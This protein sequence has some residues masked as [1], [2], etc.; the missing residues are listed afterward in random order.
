MF[1]LQNIYQKN[2]EAIDAEILSKYDELEME[3]MPLDILRKLLRKVFLKQMY[4]VKLSNHRIVN[5]T[6]E[7][8]LS[9]YD[10]D[11]MFSVEDLIA[12]MCKLSNNFTKISPDDFDDDSKTNKNDSVLIEVEGDEKKKASWDYENQGKNIEM[13][14]T[15]DDFQIDELNTKRDK[16]GEK[17]KE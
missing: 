15:K 5:N 7:E 3:L 10:N 6:L 12:I 8:L 13:N 2:L 17:I 1:K 14:D 11:G 4:P 9:N 16:H